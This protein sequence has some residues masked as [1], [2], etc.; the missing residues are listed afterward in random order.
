MQSNHTRISVFSRVLPKGQGRKYQSILRFKFVRNRA[1]FLM[2]TFNQAMYHQV[3]RWQSA[4]LKER[5]AIQY[6]DLKYS[7]LDILLMDAER[8]ERMK[9]K[10]RLEKIAQKD[11]HHKG[12]IV[13]K[14][15]RNRNWHPKIEDELRIPACVKGQR[16]RG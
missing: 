4:S 16:R 15:N 14:C 8:M 7:E 12:A 11:F 13:Y 10:A 3:G 2:R 1:F 9:E 6:G 5:I